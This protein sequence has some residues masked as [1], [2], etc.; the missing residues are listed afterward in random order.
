MKTI[1]YPMLGLIALGLL[2][3]LMWRLYS[4]RH[5]LPCPT[6]L[7]WMVE[8]DNPFT[9]TNR[10]HV[11][12]ETLGLKPTMKVLDAGCGP[13]RLT[14]PLAQKIS[15]Q[16]EVVAMDMQPGMLQRVREK[17]EALNLPHIRF[18]QAGIGEGKLEHDYYDR[19]LL[20]TVLGEIPN[21][22]FAL[23]ELFNALK[24][25]GILSI[26]EVIFDPHFQSQKTVRQLT[27]AV[28]FLEKNMIGNRFAY[29]MQLEKPFGA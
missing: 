18:L 25:G 12:I 21:R 6:W 2:I 13:G 16:G 4:R 17:A 19:I 3:S 8:L 15:P 9:K 22:E 28:G 27:T 24:P 11:I 7:G 1:L 26:T 29:T 5:T 14:I 10:A 20:V 23:K